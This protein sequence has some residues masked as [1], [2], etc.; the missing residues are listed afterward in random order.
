MGEDITLPCD[1]Q[2]QLTR[3]RIIADSIRYGRSDCTVHQ[4]CILEG[5]LVV[6]DDVVGVVHFPAY[7]HCR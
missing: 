5:E 1:L 6:H 4:G 2:L 7:C 3:S